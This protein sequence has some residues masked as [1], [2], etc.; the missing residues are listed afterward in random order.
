MMCYYL[1]VHFQGQRVKRKETTMWWQVNALITRNGILVLRSLT[2]YYFLIGIG[3]NIPTASVHRQR[4]PSCSLQHY[5]L[6]SS[7]SSL[8]ILPSFVL[9]F[10]TV[11]GDLRWPRRLPTLLLFEFWICFPPL[12]PALPILQHSP[13][14][15]PW[16]HLILEAFAYYNAWTLKINLGPR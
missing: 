7:H 15:D 8:S 3:N 4:A 13:R 16:G 14:S 1:N 9:C 10:S 12:I 11:I 6:S 5:L 2:E